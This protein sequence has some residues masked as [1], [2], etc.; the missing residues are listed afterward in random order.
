[1]TG[2][3]PKSKKVGLWATKKLLAK[4]IPPR[5]FKLT[6]SLGTV[7]T[8]ITLLKRDVEY[9]FTAEIPL[10][11]A[12]S[13]SEFLALIAMMDRLGL[14]IYCVSVCA[15]DMELG[16]ELGL[17]RFNLTVATAVLTSCGVEPYLRSRG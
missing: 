7:S 1:M 12:S 6:F 8:P 5:K 11:G 4:S 15:G 10:I 14:I 2:D 13:G 16:L 17:G 9:P 3:S